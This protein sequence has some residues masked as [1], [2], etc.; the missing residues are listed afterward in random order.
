MIVI[1]GWYL[2]FRHILIPLMKMNCIYNEFIVMVHFYR[3]FTP[4]LF[5]CFYLLLPI[6]RDVPLISVHQNRIMW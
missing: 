4:S 1:T 2:E 3:H 5:P 6:T